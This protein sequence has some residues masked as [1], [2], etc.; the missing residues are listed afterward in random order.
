MQTRGFH[1]APGG[2]LGQRSGHQCATDAAKTSNRGNLIFSEGVMRA[3]V[4][5][6]MARQAAYELVHRSAL[7]TS[8]MLGVGRRPG[9]ATVIPG[10]AGE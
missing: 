6:G 9:G 3:L 8:A 1:G 2:G 7:A 5:E 10:P 4:H